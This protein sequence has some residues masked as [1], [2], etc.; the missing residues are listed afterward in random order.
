MFSWGGEETGR[1]LGWHFC[2]TLVYF[3]AVACCMTGLSNL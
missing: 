1:H 3:G 2:T